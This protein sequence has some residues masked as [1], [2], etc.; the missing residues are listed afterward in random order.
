M[1]TVAAVLL[2]LAAPVVRAVDWYW[3]QRCRSCG[4]SRWHHV[5]HGYR[6][7]FDEPSNCI[8]LDRRGD[9]LCGG[10]R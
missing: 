7:E 6:V 4:H 5:S 1:R 8:A 2:W 9:C 3:E 10:F